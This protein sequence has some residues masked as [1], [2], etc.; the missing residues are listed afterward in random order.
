MS[1]LSESNKVTYILE[2]FRLYKQL[3]VV[4]V[5][6]V[7]GGGGYCFHTSLKFRIKEP[8]GP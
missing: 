4:V 7:V 8:E 3:T 2:K 1:R 5:V 6:V